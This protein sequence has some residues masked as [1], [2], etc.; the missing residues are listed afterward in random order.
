MDDNF[1]CLVGIYGSG[2]MEEEVKNMAEVSNQLLRSNQIIHKGSYVQYPFEN[3][4][5]KL[6][7][8]I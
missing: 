4:L 7:G 3:D 8:K 2:Y 5:S 6:P 1:F